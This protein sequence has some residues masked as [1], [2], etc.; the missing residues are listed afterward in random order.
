MVV[1]VHGVFM[2]AVIALM[3]AEMNGIVIGRVLIPY[4]LVIL[5]FD[6][7]VFLFYNS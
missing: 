6:K 1:F 4:Q 5:H 3:H 7:K 2:G